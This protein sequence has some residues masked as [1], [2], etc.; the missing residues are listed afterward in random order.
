LI[1]DTR[2]KLSMPASVTDENTSYSRGHY[3]L[4]KKKITLQLSVFLHFKKSE[5]GSSI[6]QGREKPR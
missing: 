5:E 3:F 6:V 2:N 1:I 4:K